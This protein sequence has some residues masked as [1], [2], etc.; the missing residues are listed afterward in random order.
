MMH[1]THTDASHVPYNDTYTYS[2]LIL[3]TELHVEAAAAQWL[4]NCATNRKDA[5][6][7]PD[8]VNGIFH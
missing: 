2:F 6:S 4:R 1:I 8:G 5:G 7:I 3:S